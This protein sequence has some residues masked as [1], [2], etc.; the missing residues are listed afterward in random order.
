MTVTVTWINLYKL[1]GLVVIVMTLMLSIGS[2]IVSWQLHSL[3]SRLEERLKVYQADQID[4][5]HRIERLENGR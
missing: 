2:A 3:D 5:R 1:A 4:M